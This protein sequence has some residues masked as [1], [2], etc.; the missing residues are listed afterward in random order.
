MAE[1]FAAEYESP[2]PAYVKRFDG[3]MFRSSVEEAA[4]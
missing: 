2:S 4:A 1:L 3:E